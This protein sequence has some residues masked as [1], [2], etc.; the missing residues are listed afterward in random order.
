MG[1]AVLLL[2]VATAAPIVACIAVRLVGT[3]DVGVR[4][5]RRAPFAWPHH[6]YLVGSG[7]GDLVRTYLL[8][9]FVPALEGLIKI[10]D[11]RFVEQ[12]HALLA[13][14]SLPDKTTQHHNKPRP[15]TIHSEPHWST[16]TVKRKQ[17]TG[18]TFCQWQSKEKITMG[19]AGTPVR[20]T[21]QRGLLQTPGWG[22]GKSGASRGW[23]CS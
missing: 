9:L 2:A 8:S 18:D 12:T 10:H 6:V 7:S 14:R 5:R 3:A 17:T 22:N 13:H 19:M 21:G 1:A 11:L 16:C 20:A 15:S 4:R 23:R